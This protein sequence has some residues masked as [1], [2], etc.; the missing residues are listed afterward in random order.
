MMGT[1]GMSAYELAS[2]VKDIVLPSG[3]ASTLMVD[4]YLHQH[5]QEHGNGIAGIHLI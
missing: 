5:M 1:A 3:R 2:R 4:Q